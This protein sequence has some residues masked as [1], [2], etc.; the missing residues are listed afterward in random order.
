MGRNLSP[1][2]AA[3]GGGDGEGTGPSSRLK[4]RPEAPYSLPGTGGRIGSPVTPTAPWARIE[5][6]G[7][8]EAFLQSPQSQFVDILPPQPG[9]F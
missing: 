5:R 3:G 9:L 1:L 6:Q 8:G 7:G 2:P 4:P